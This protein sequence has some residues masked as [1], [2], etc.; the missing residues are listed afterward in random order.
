MKPTGFM[1]GGGGLVSPLKPVGF[2]GKLMGFGC[3]AETHW[4]PN[5]TNGFHGT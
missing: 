3:A 2:M 4:F 1:G 5:E